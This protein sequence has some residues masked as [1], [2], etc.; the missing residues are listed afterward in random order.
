[1]NKSNSFVEYVNNSL[2]NSLN[3]IIISLNINNS[4]NE[5]NS[6]VEN[7]NNSLDI[8]IIRWMKIILSL[9]I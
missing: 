5:N 9:N 7:I 4:L 2:N 6:F 8:K 3:K 1:M